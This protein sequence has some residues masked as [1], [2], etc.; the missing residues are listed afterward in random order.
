MKEC[1][2]RNGKRKMSCLKYNLKN[3]R[4]KEAEAELLEG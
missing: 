4:K 2:E 3:K 1:A